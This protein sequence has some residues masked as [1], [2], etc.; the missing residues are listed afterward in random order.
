[1]PRACAR[2]FRSSRLFMTVSGLCAAAETGA[3]PHTRARAAG[4]SNLWVP[5]VHCTNYTSSP[6]CK[7]HNKYNASASST[8]FKDGRGL[9][10]P[11]GSGVVLGYISE[12]DTR[13]GGLHLKNASFGEV[14]VE[15]GEVWVES[16][17]DGLF[18]LAFPLLSMPPGV[19]PPFDKAMKDGLLAKN[20]F[21]FYLSSND[22]DDTSM[23]LL[24]GT[25]SK[26]Y[27]GEF[28]SVPFNGL[29][30]LL[31]YWLITGDSIEVA[32]KDVG[33]CSKCALVVDTG[34][35]I[36]TGPPG[37]IDPLLKAI[38]NVSSDCSNVDSLPTLT[39]NIASKPFTLEPSFYV[40]KAPDSNGNMECQL[41]IEA[42]NPGIPLWILGDPFL[43]KYYTLFDRD[44]NTV[45]FATAVQQ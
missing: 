31:G 40:L 34:T 22:G 36:L 12:D 8:Y 10:L 29:Q 26:Y 5:S 45:S 23:L 6:G 1:M 37:T 9:F 44:Q 28:T 32:G 13:F 42:L 21:S 25:D 41:G 24:G 33:V 11:Y 14:T 7:N 30:F 27:T 3:A 38:G 16:P 19:T 20:Q 4:S 15:P 18:G 39:F 2:A 35:S 43:R 17:F